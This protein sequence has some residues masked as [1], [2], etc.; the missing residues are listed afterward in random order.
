MLVGILSLRNHRYHPNRR[1]ME[2]ARTQ[3]HR[4]MLLHPARM[5]LAVTPEGFRVIH[6]GKAALPE[7]V[8]PRV[9]STIREYPLALVR[10]MEGMGIRMVNNSEAVERARNKFRVL[11]ALA[12]QGV[13][14]P[15]SCYA[16]NERNLT[17]AARNLGS[18]PL[19]IKTAQGRQG[20]GVFLAKDAG[21]AQRLFQEHPPALGQGLVLQRFVPPED[22][23]RDIRVL[24][25]GGR[26]VS[27]MALRP[28]RGEFR[29]NV[30]LHGRAEALHLSKPMERVAVK[31]TAAVGLD[32]AGVDMIQK[33]DG[34]LL[35]VDV[36]YSPGFKGL[37]KCTGA[38]IASRII[39][40]T[41]S[42][43]EPGQDGSIES[44]GGVK[45]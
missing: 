19:V 22:R 15:E 28:R 13:P 1:L 37:E 36:N 23:R 39:A 14:I 16:S 32:I 43:F 44:R 40:F 31:A 33:I 9:G 21:E 10:H 27:A 12:R 30:H 24:V 17:A 8:L 29:A 38:D 25:M 35:V 41:A 45:P 26:A 42:F 5:Y 4:A 2:A 11:Q 7:V 3:G 6:L 18:R 20:R 34:T